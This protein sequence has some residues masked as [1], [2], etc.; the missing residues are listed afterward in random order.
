MLTAPDPVPNSKICLGFNC[1]FIIMSI[2]R[3]NNFPNLICPDGN[4]NCKYILKGRLMNRQPIVGEPLNNIRI[5][6]MGS[7][8]NNKRRISQIIQTSEF[9]K[10]S[11]FRFAFQTINPLATGNVNINLSNNF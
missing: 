11:Q 10:K 4:Y 8:L 7:L 5:Q 6:E 3:R 2:N 1:K 9:A